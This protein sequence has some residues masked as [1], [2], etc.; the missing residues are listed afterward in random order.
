MKITKLQQGNVLLDTW[1]YTENTLMEML[2]EHKV[3][4]LDENHAI[5]YDSSKYERLG[6]KPDLRIFWEKGNELKVAF[7]ESC[8]VNI[9]VKNNCNYYVKF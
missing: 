3:F 6:F 9:L 8:F 2:K 5:S 1:Y 7:V 4:Y